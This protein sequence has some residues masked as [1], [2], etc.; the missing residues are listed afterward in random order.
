MLDLNMP[1]TNCSNCGAALTPVAARNYLYCEHCL[2]FYFLE[3]FEQSADQVLRMHAIEDTCCPVCDVNLELGS[4]ERREVQ[5]CERCRGILLRC[6][7]FSEIVQIRRAR[8]AGT[9]TPSPLDP[10]ELRRHIQCPICHRSMETHPYC[11]PGAVVI[12]SCNRC[13]V[14]WVDHGEIAQIVKAPGRRQ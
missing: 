8:Q 12:D 7:D 6:A 9:A 4:M 14:L 10:Q 3:P 5:F 1:L 2:S 11:G 13:A